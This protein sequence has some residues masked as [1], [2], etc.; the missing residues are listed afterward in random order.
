MPVASRRLGIPPFTGT[1]SDSEY[2]FP[3]LSGRPSESDPA[4][5]TEPP[6]S[7]S[8][9]HRPSR[10]AA[11]CRATGYLPIANPSHTG[12]TVTV[13]RSE[14]CDTCSNGIGPGT[15]PSWP[16]I[17]QPGLILSESHQ[18]LSSRPGEIRCV[19]GWQGRSRGA[20]QRPAPPPGGR[21]FLAPRA[22]RP[23]PGALVFGA[24]RPTPS[25]RCA[26][27]WRPAPRAPLPILGA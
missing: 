17:R 26:R 23:A 15:G 20:D 7:L 11:A 9:S 2:L 3:P 22:P 8:R 18:Q 4:S 16:G 10:A 12:T 27:I 13:R 24:P 5:P 1:V 14:P 21:S 19:Q 6:A 25:L